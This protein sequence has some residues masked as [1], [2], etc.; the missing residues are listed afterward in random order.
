[1]VIDEFKGLEWVV[2]RTDDM[3]TFPQP[4]IKILVKLRPAAFSSPE[5]RKALG[6]PGYLSYGVRNQG[7]MVTLLLPR[8]DVRLMV[9]VE[10]IER[11]KLAEV[12]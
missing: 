6:N 3:R 10:K 4:G 1:M 9:H 8:K 11:W 12:K 5:I 2:L 7:Y